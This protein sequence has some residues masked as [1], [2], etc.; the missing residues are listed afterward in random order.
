MSKRLLLALAFLFSAGLI[1]TAPTQS[2]ATE[3]LPA[4]IKAGETRL[5]LNGSGAR[6]KAFMELYNAGLYLTKSSNN[7]KA[8]I[9]ADEPMAIR[10]KITSGWVSQS[11]LVESLEDG[12]TNSTG[13]NTREIRTEIDQ[14]R[15]CFQDEISKG[16]VFDMLSLPNKGVVVS[17]NGKYK[18]TVSGAKFKQSLF[19]IWLSDK[20]A[21]STLK[22]AM[23]SPKTVR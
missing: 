12:F 21:D 8:I 9:A 18:G 1:G 19:G 16:D 13:G 7:P 6:T 15:A 2:R 22:Q 14:F 5:I 3:S 4:E 11:N 20:P 17:K 23:V 10:I